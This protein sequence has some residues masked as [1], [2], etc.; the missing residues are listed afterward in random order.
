MKENK[1]VKELK[2]IA[3]KN[4]GLLQPEVVVEAARPITSPL[5]SRFEWNNTEAAQRYRIWQ[6]RQLISVTVETLAA[7]GESFDVFVSLSP[8]R[9]RKGGGYRVM[10]EVLSDDH[11]RAQLLQDALDELAIFRDKYQK[12]RELAVIFAAMKKVK[13]R[14]GR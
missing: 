3:I 12:L 5:H 1:V 6:A 13:V 2:R 4:G 9:G 8:D 11:M 10:T 14:H 7:T